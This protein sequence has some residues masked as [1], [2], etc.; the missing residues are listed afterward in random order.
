MP[1][2]ATIEQRLQFLAKR[3][4][5]PGLATIERVLRDV[6]SPQSR[7]P[8]VLV[9]GTNGKGSTANLLASMGTAAGYR[10]GLFTSP[11][12][13]HFEEQIR[14]DGQ[15][16]TSQ[17][18][19]KIWD[20]VLDQADHLCPNAITAFEVLTASAFVYFAEQGVDLVICEVGMGG[21]LD[22]TNALNPVLSI[23]TSLG[24]DHA[25]FL[26]STLKEVA[27]HKAAIFRPR[28]P[29]LIAWTEP[30]E[31]EQFLLD[32]AREIGA[33]PHHLRNEVDFLEV[34][35][36]EDGS[37]QVILRTHQSK[38]DIHLSLAGSH[39]THNLATAIRAAEEL[40]QRGWSS[41]DAASIQ[42]GAIQCRWPG[43]LETLQIGDRTVLLDAAH[44]AQGAAALA[45][46]L[47]TRAVPFEVLFGALADK[48]AT[49]ML[50]SL[51][52]A[53]RLWLTAPL[54]PRAWDPGAFV[55]TANLTHCKIEI[56]MV[57]AEALERALDQTSGWLVV[58]GSLRLVGDVRSLLFDHFHPIPSIGRLP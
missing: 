19:I 31:G 43:R 48:D 46:Y 45:N 26:G 6:G 50:S 33:A 39:Q 42:Q 29:A 36:H 15:Q 41:L 3:G 24:L 56:P 30:V 58:T 1:I 23:V 57:V 35:P 20:Q 34:H 44:N 27:S 13:Q 11:H 17:R 51:S 37:Q 47:A 9:G 21:R 7:F 55:P 18:L 8:S 16:I 14:I 12:L 10:V 40:C 5:R 52:A 28:H 32:Q 22:C 53:R 38:Y 54:S 25:A 4:I 49:Q 2:T